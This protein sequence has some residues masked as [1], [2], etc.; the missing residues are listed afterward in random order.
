[1]NTYRCIIAAVIAA[2][3]G[4]IFGMLMVP[5][6]SA[7]CGQV[8]DGV[9]HFFD[10]EIKCDAVESPRRVESPRKDHRRHSRARAEPRKPRAARDVYTG[11]IKPQPQLSAASGQ[12]LALEIF[13]SRSL[14]GTQARLRL[15]EL[16][17]EMPEL[18]VDEE[19]NK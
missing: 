7:E 18:L 1:M 14:V 15:R 19:P 4:F 2:T 12:R 17:D 9:L 6:H 13:G 10:R 11:P 3:I 16:F 8:S 5:A